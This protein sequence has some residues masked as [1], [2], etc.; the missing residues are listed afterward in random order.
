MNSQFL[1]RNLKFKSSMYVHLTYILLEIKYACL[2]DLEIKYVSSS[3]L[4]TLS[5]KSLRI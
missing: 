4:H 3:D 1:K 5:F 2:S